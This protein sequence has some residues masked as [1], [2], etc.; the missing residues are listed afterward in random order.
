VKTKKKVIK[1]TSKKLGKHKLLTAI[2]IVLISVLCLLELLYFIKFK[3]FFYASEDEN[4]M[5][6]SLIEDLLL[7]R[8]IRKLSLEEKVGALFV[9][10]F[11]GVSLSPEQTEFFKDNHFIHFL[12]LEENIKSEEELIKLTGEL[13]GLNNSLLPSLIGVDQEGGEVARIKF[14]DI[15]NTPQNQIFTLEKAYEIGKNRGEILKSL[16]INLNFSPVVEIIRDNNSYLAL[17]NRAFLGEKEK[18]LGLSEAMIQGYKAGGIIPVPKHFPGGLGRNMADPHQVLP[19]LD[20]T[21]EEL[22]KDLYIFKALAQNNQ[23]SVMMTTH[24]YYPLID[25]DNP[26]TLSET[27]VSSILRQSLGFR[28]V[29]L[30]DDLKMKGITNKYSVPKAALK[31]FQAGSDLLLIS[32]TKEEQKQA[33][34]VILKAVKNGE[35]KEKRLNNSLKRILK[36]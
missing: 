29:I 21:R 36:I 7:E 24:L 1:K 9:L 33:Y 25:K 27:F 5:A 20:I 22:D 16:G 18:V 10:G 14:K 19:V 3:P 31:A 8:K 26:V 2:F 30:T 12:L 35:I 34:E 28:G 32:G 4:Q 11:K 17:G 6:N 13:K 15:D 23:A